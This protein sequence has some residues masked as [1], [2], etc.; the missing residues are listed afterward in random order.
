MRRPRTRRAFSLIEVVVA[1]LLIAIVVFFV[2]TVFSRGRATIDSNARK[3]DAMTTVHA[4]VEELRHVLLTCGWAWTPSA[5]DAGDPPGGSRLLYVDGREWAFDGDSSRLFV[6]TT[7]RPGILRDVRFFSSRPFV[8][9]YGVSCSRTAPVHDD[10]EAPTGRADRER[11]SLVSA[12]FLEAHAA[13]V[14]ERNHVY[15]RSATWDVN[16]PPIHYGTAP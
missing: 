15:E 8:V 10:A 9:T 13:E 5:D 6:D 16:G 2:L 1:S 7:A 3:L 12:V 11:A 4:K 14:R